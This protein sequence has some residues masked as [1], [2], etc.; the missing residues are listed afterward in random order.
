MPE[1]LEL[2]DAPPVPELLALL[3]ADADALALDEVVLVA[4]AP[5]VDPPQAQNADAA[6]KP[7][8]ARPREGSI[9]RG[10]IG[11]GIAEA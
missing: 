11:L 6:S 4:A 9:A 5:L 2:L 3:D 7:T 8:P 1:L 10:A